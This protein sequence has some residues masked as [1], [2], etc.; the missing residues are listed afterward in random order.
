MRSGITDGTLENSLQILPV[1]AGDM[2]FVDAGTVHAIWP[3]SILLEPSKT[4]M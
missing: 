2:I 1:V 4:A 3:G